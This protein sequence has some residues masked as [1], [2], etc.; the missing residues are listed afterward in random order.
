MKLRRLLAMAW[1]EALQIRRDPR[2]LAIALLMPLMQMGLLGYGVSLDIHHVPLCVDDRAH[3]QL[4]RALSSRLAAGQWFDIVALP[5]GDAQLR[6]DLDRG[7]CIAAVVIP[8]DFSRRLADTGI[9]SLQAVFDASD[10]NT[11]NVA[12][13][14]LQGIVAQ[15][16]AELQASWYAAQGRRPQARGQVDL[17]PRTWFNE[18]LDSRNFIIPGVVAVILALIGA[19]LTSLT[20]SREWERG[21]MEQLISTPVTA[22]ELMLGKLLPYLAISFVDALLCLGLAVFWF[23]VPFRGSVVSLLGATLLF[24][25]VVLGIGYLISVRIRSQLGAS[26]IALL[27]TMLPTTLLSGYTFPIDQM[28]APIRAITHLVYAR[29]YVSILRGLF[30]KGSGLA[31]LWQPLLG[32]LSFAVVIVWLAARAF[33]KRL[34]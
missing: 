28:P 19:Q 2:S 13:G 8:Q 20:I 31:A 7:R 15:E 21:T 26:Q 9:A 12:L 17:E 16:N 23:Q 32:L 18:S 5:S 27:V 14:Y 30:L 25:M 6:E 4:S 33:H 22:L 24:S 1:K 34:D 3:S 10:A 29:Y 11:A